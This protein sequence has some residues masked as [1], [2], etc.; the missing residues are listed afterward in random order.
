MQRKPSRFEFVNKMRARTD[1]QEQ[2]AIEETQRYMEA[3]AQR[4]KE[5]REQ[6]YSQNSKINK[7]K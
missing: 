3:K 1:A 5:K 7:K 4:K 2:K 6:K